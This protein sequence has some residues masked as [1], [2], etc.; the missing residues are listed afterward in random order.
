[1]RVALIAFGCSSTAFNGQAQIEPY[2]HSDW[3]QN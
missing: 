2:F 3:A 1:M